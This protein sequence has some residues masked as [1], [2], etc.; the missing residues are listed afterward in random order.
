MKQY[1]IQKDKFNEFINELVQSGLDVYAP[2]EFKGKTYFSK[3]E[4]LSNLDNQK[5]TV[6]SAKS[7]FFPHVEELMSYK[8]QGKDIHI[9]EDKN[10]DKETLLIGAKPCDTAGVGYMDKFFMQ[11]NPDYHFGKKKEKTTVISI[12]CAEADEHCFCTSVGSN[13]GDTKGAD[14]N[15]TDM[16]NGEYLIEVISDKG[17]KLITKKSA[18]FSGC[19]GVDKQQF[20]AKV[21]QKFDINLVNEKIA[22]SYDDEK[23]KQVSLACLGCGS[24]A[25][26]CPTCT[27]F[28]I[29]DEK[30]PVSGKRMRIWDSCGFG[31][32]TLHAS[33]HNPREVQSGR[34]KHRVMHKFRYSNENMNM[35]GCTGC[36][37][38]ARNCPAGMSIVDSL[39]IILEA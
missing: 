35:T 4:K 37:K 34:W 17:E 24:C 29:Q 8:Q 26:S 2:Q 5:P 3:I 25:F 13:P 32:F 28:D 16:K 6:L 38:C 36:G 27:C 1:K 14:I 15:I 19:E 7:L 23:W 33:G 39:K 22:S 31:L 12:S 9:N 10:E 30:N 18:A 21:A 11:E 20:L